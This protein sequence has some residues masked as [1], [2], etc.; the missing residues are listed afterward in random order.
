MNPLQ[1]RKRRQ[2]RDRHPSWPLGT[3][4]SDGAA[5][6]QDPMQ[7][8]PEGLDPP[9]MPL[10][11]SC[12]RSR[13]PK[14]VVL[15]FAMCV[16]LMWCYFSMLFPFPFLCFFYFLFVSGCLEEPRKPFLKPSRSDPTLLSSYG[17]AAWLPATCCHTLRT[18]S[19]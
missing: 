18:R 13:A 4:G 2:F 5:E 6:V 14:K 7:A 12:E 10:G 11:T 15:P 8:A 3:R 19:R 16:V 17:D 1:V 9:Y